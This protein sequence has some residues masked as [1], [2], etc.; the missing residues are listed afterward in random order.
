MSKMRVFGV[1]LA[2][3]GIVMAGSGIAAAATIPLETPSATEIIAPGEP[4]PSGGT[5]SAKGLTKAIEALSTG[6]SKA[7][8]APTTP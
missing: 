5:G 6:S 4:D 8:P 3:A 7:K 1:A 2:A